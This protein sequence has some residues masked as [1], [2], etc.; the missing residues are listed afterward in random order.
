[1]TTAIDINKLIETAQ[2][3]ASRLETITYESGKTS[4]VALG[5]GNATEGRFRV[6]VMTASGRTTWMRTH[7]RKSFY[8]LVDGEWTRATKAEFA[9]AAAQEVS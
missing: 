8:L 5:Y 3:N 7:Y 6:Y 2:A 9:A 1:M 4:Q